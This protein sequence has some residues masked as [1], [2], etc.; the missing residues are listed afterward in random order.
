[1]DYGVNLPHR[2]DQLRIYLHEAME[3][4][5]P[6]SLEKD[7]PLLCTKKTASTSWKEPTLRR[8]EKMNHHAK[9][10]TIRKPS[11]PRRVSQMV[12]HTQRP[13]RHHQHHQHFPVCIRAAVAR[14]VVLGRPAKL[15]MPTAVGMKPPVR[16]GG[17]A[18]QNTT[19]YG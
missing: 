7:L 12:C 14:H 16:H 9:P 10:P 15:L 11:R 19:G 18:V 1:M 17:R 2:V 13:T 6:L 5:A 4:R 3:F 8:K